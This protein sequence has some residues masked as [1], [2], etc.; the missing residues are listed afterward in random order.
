[1]A[2]KSKKPA[3]QPMLG[4]GSQ[5][6]GNAAASNSSREEAPTQGNSDII[7]SL[8]SPDYHVE[9]T[10]ATDVLVQGSNRFGGDISWKTT[11]SAPNGFS[12]TTDHSQRGQNL[13]VPFD[14]GAPAIAGELKHGDH[15]TMK[16][17]AEVNG[18]KDVEE[19]DFIMNIPTEELQVWEVFFDNADQDQDTGGAKRLDPLVFDLNRDGKLDTTDGTQTGNGQ[20]D[21]STVLFDIDP[22]RSSLSGWGRSSPGHRP[23]Y[24]EGRNNSQVPSVPG[25]KAVYDTGKTESTDKHGRGR[26]TE[27]PSKGNTAKIYD[28][29]GKLV[30]FWDKSKWGR[31][32][33]GRIGQYYWEAK[34]NE[35]VEEKTEWIKGTGDGFL[36][37]DQNGNGKIDSNSE[38]MFEFDINGNKVFENGFEKLAHYFDEDQN[39][40]IEGS[41]LEDLKFWVDDGDAKT[42]AGELRELSEFG[43]RKI[44]L[45]QNGEL[46]STTTATKQEL[47]DK[48]KKA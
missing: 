1:M 48:N 40:I 23:G 11:W 34:G 25:G 35:R 24:Y 43:I 18:K 17:E 6:S 32:H 47:L 4:P 16:V 26:W 7:E 10:S 33:G 31:S 14:F 36:V 12:E 41:E 30:G 5:I 21:G 46:T 39:G 28:A 37:W 27:D 19:R 9:P 2:A 8:Y 20:L 13:S 45:P 29:S 38:M 3:Q 44:T 42:E 22:T 15:I